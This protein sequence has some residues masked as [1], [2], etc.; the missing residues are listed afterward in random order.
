MPQ[1]E[2]LLYWAIVPPGDYKSSQVVIDA[3]GNMLNSFNFVEEGMDTSISRHCFQILD[4]FTRAVPLTPGYR[5]TVESPYVTVQ[6]AQF[7][8]NGSE[9][10]LMNYTAQVLIL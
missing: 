6:T 10:T 9:T 8:Y 2:Q 5:L 3:I 4:D 1:L 7:P